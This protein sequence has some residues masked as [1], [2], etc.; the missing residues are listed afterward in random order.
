VGLVGRT[1]V[2]I[3]AEAT[4]RAYDPDDPDEDPWAAVDLANRAFGQGASFTLPQLARGMSTL[5]NGG[6]LVQPHLVVDGEQAAVKPKR[7]LKAKIARQAKDILRHVTGS[8]SRYAKGSLIPGFDIGGKTG[9][10]QIWDTSI[11]NWKKHRF[12]H[13]FVG[14][15]GGRKQ[16]YVIAVRIEEPIPYA[17][18]TQ[19][20]IPVRVESFELYQM[21][22]RA[23][24][25]Q[26][27]M[28]RLKDPNAGRPIIGT[29]AARMLTPERNR[30]AV[31]V[32]KQ[33]KRAEQRRAAK[34]K[35][36][37][38][39]STRAAKAAAGP[40]PDR[41]KSGGDA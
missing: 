41:G 32:A 18:P 34:A 14:F 12:N 7:V 29:P 13:S 21:V 11:A 8:V 6:K 15:V 9:T 24:I 23:T 38:A 25:Q 27:G 16:E 5:V 1:G 31:K 35:A 28:R 19:G 4:G 2:D 20:S 36:D 10:A 33:Q 3:S 22:A 17:K 39:G 37:T 26:L 30:Q 40:E